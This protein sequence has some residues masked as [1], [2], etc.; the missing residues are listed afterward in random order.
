MATREGNDNNNGSKK[1]RPDRE[2]FD[3]QRTGRRPRPSRSEDDYEPFGDY[4]E[5]Y[6]DGGFGSWN[7][8]TS[9]GFPNFKKRNKRPLHGY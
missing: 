6:G 2:E 5:E 8:R 4:E 7:F 9:F 3:G 1:R